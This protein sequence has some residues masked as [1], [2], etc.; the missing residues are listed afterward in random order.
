MVSLMATLS[1]DVQL[2]SSF[3]SVSFFKAAARPELDAAS[4]SA[5]EAI[6][7]CFEATEPRLF[8]AAERAVAPPLARGEG[9][10]ARLDGVTEDRL[11][12]GV[13]TADVAIR[14]NRNGE[15]GEFVGEGERC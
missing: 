8:R 12:E 6:D 9:V 3:S 10:D 4:A 11:T 13:R 14:S 7:D 5:F 2:T 1:S 15:R